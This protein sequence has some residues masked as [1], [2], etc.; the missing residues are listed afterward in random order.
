MSMKLNSVRLCPKRD[1]EMY[2]SKFFL[3]FFFLEGFS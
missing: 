1:L 3:V 2:V